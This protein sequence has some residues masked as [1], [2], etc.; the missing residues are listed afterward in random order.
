MAI[1]YALLS[2]GGNPTLRLTL[3]NPESTPYAVTHEKYDL[4]P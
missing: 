1:F 2:L 4:L 3:A